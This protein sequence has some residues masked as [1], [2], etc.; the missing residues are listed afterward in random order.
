MCDAPS[1]AD[2]QQFMGDIGGARKTDA[3]ESLR[4]IFQV[5]SAYPQLADEVFCMI[6]KQLTKNRSQKS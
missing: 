4:M 5:M 2:V 1:L 3:V 6:M